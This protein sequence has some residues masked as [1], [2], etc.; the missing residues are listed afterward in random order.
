MSSCIKFKRTFRS[1][2]SA[3]QCTC[4]EP[5]RMTR[6]AQTASFNSGA[7][8]LAGLHNDDRKLRLHAQ[9]G[10]L[11]RCRFSLSPGNPSQTA[12][13]LLYK[14]STSGHR[15]PLLTPISS[16]S[17]AKS[18]GA[19][20]CPS[21]LASKSAVPCGRTLAQSCPGGILLRA[22][23]AWPCLLSRTT[24]RR[25]RVRTRGRPSARSAELQA[26]H[27]RPLQNPRSPLLKA[28]PNPTCG[29]CSS[30]VDGASH[31]SYERPLKF[32]ARAI[33]IAARSMYVWPVP[34]LSSICSTACSSVDVE[35]KSTAGRTACW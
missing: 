29:A 28:P 2:D 21:A 14:I 8:C 26:I 18:S 27:R 3:S 15:L 22:R 1:C 20:A 30:A 4:C 25:P 33:L 24:M 35:P 6:T 19:I 9:L 5:I 12:Q 16:R 11:W 23:R 7:G 13:G 32:R 17:D 34:V 31:S 10:N